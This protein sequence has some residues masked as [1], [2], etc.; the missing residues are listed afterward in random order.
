MA[1]IPQRNLMAEPARRRTHLMID[2]DVT[3]STHRTNWT[4]QNGVVV[5]LVGST[6]TQYT[7][8]AL[9]PKDVGTIL[10]VLFDKASAAAKR[11]EVKGYLAALD[12]ADLIALA[13]EALAKRG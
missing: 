5:V 9:T 1:F 11:K 10:P 7:K 6:G 4:N 3:A 13:K 12:D 2:A 8:I